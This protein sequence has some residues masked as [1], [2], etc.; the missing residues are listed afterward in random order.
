MTRERETG[1]RRQETTIQ[2]VNKGDSESTRDY[3]STRDRLS[4]RNEESDN[5][6]SLP[7]KKLGLKHEFDDVL[8]STKPSWERHVTEMADNATWLL[9]EHQ[10]EYTIKMFR[11]CINYKTSDSSWSPTHWTLHRRMV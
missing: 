7:S 5:H 1:T 9:R 3:A 6:T 8:P 2:L 11:S 10:L 4:T